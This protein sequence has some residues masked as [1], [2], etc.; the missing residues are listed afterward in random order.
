MILLS[1]SKAFR[2]SLQYFCA[3]IWMFLLMA[4]AEEADDEDVV[5]VDP[6]AD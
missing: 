1:S 2:Q 4:D 6:P 5:L 3:S